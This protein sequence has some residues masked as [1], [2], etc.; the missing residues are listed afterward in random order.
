MPRF[1]HEEPT[2]HTAHLPTQLPINYLISAVS[3]DE[4]FM[5]AAHEANARNEQFW[6]GWGSKELAETHLLRR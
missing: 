1:Y 6:V 3:A 4:A 2:E 5:S